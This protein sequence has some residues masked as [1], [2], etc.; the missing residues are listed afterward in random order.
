MGLIN[1]AAEG[2]V[3]TVGR[4]NHRHTQTLGFRR[5]LKVVQRIGNGDRGAVQVEQ[6]TGE[7]VF[8]N[9][10]ARVRQLRIDA[11]EQTDLL[12]R[13]HLT[14]E[15][16][17][18]RIRIHAPV[19]INVQLTVVVEVLEFQSIHIQDRR[20]ALHVGQLDL[21]GRFVRLDDRE[22]TIR[23][24]V[25]LLCRRFLRAGL[26]RADIHDFS[27]RNRRGSFR[28]RCAC[29]AHEHGCRQ[30]QGDLFHTEFL[31]STFSSSYT[32]PEP[33]GSFSPTERPFD[34]QHPLIP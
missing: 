24:E 2:I 6:L 32:L 18:T 1:V 28:E 12:L 25:F 16:G 34:F 29:V 4:V 13:S 30:K 23:F 5:R 9:H 3:F 33:E 15:V 20:H 19:L 26:L 7:L 14:D 10:L 8:L 17:D 27:R 22:R 31:L 11:E 21:S